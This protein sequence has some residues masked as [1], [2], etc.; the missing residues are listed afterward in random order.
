MIRVLVTDD[1]PM[2]RF[3][4]RMLLDAAEGIEVVGEASD[5]ASAMARARE[6]SPDLVLTDLRMPGMDGIAATRQLLALPN[7]PRSWC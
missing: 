7:P 5:G 3:G 2:V 1:E 4:L 6:L